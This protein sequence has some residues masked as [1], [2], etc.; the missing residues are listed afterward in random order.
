MILYVKDGR[1]F[2][3][4]AMAYS[5]EHGPCSSIVTDQDGS[6]QLRCAHLP[7]KAVREELFDGFWADLRKA[8]EAST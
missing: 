1:H 2:G 5:S 7:P 4:S 6:S 8:E 3:L